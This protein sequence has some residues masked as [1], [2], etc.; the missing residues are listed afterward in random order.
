MQT[1]KAFTLTEILFVMGIISVLL[2][3]QVNHLSS[4]KETR[5]TANPFM[6]SLILKLNYLKSKAIK[7]GKPITLIFNHYSNKITVKEP[8]I[9]NNDIKLPDHSFIYLQTNIN[10]LTFDNKG[11]TNKFGTVYISVNKVIYKVV[12]H[13]EKGRMRYEKKK[14]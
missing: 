14:N 12:F 11:N 7:D 1:S 5:E 8:S 10:Y 2:I 13:I 9:E 6:N 3:V 4:K